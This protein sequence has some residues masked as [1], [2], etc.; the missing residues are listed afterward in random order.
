MP[1]PASGARAAPS[2]K[3]VLVVEDEATLAET[4]RSWLEHAGYDVCGLAARADEALDLALTNCPHLAVMDTGA[5]LYGLSRRREGRSR[6]DRP[7]G[8]AER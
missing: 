8:E 5:V 6:R 4:L 7:P 2:S 3:R 1:T